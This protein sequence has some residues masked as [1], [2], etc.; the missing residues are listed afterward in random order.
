M[1]MWFLVLHTNIILARANSLG[2]NTLAFSIPIGCSLEGI[3]L[4]L[5]KNIRPDW[6]KLSRDKHSS[7]FW[8]R[9]SDEEEQ[10]SFWHLTPVVKTLY[11]FWIHKR[12]LFFKNIYL[13]LR[14][15]ISRN[16]GRIAM[17]SFLQMKMRWRKFEGMRA[18]ADWKGTRQE[19]LIGRRGRSLHPWWIFA[20]FVKNFRIFVTRVI[21]LF[22]L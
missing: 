9:V 2:T 12:N 20:I 19:N 22:L 10:K 7:L 5:P 3:Q 21:K 8:N 18:L 6:K 1:W 16:W 17:R 11:F 14:Q 13:F 4:V 15:N